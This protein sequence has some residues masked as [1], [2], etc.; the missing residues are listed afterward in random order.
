MALKHAYRIVTADTAEGLAKGVQQ[1]LDEGWTCQGSLAVVPNPDSLGYRPFHYAQP[2]LRHLI[3]GPEG[4][5]Y[6]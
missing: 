5:T 6:G 3:D 4:E 1:C 2:M